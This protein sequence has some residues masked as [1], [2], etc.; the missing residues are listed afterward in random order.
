MVK[1]ATQEIFQTAGVKNKQWRKKGKKKIHN[2]EVPS[3]T[4]TGNGTDIVMTANVYAYQLNWIYI[5]Q[6]IID[7]NIYA[8]I[9]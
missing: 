2:S 5:K 6:I 9:I 4:H 3:P 1:Q 7:C 8:I